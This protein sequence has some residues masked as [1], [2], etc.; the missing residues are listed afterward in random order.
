M[1]N[2][3]KGYQMSYEAYGRSVIFQYINEDVCHYKPRAGLINIRSMFRQDAA[4]LTIFQG[5]EHYQIELLEPVMEECQFPGGCVIFEQGTPADWLY[6]LARG[7]V[8]IRFKPYDG[9]ALTVAIIGSGGVFGWSAAMGREVYTSGVITLS[10]VAAYRI[11]SRSLDQLCD[12]D[13][14]TGKLLL[15]RLASAIAERLQG[16]QQQIYALLSQRIAQNGECDKNE[17]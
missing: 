14:H 10:E 15:N 2:E 4:K 8:I 9:P 7:E 11:S 6:I 5:L 12:C 17:G 16:N 13:P 3:I 1:Q